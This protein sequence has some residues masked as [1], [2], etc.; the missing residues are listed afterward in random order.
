MATVKGK[1][2]GY[3]EKILAMDCETSG[4][5]FNGDDPSVGY[6]S[7]SWGLIVADAEKLKPIEELYVEIKWD[8]VSKWNRKA[9]KVH[10]LSVSYLE[11]NGV[12]EEEAVTRMGSLI[13][14]YWGPKNC[15]HTLGHNVVT[16]DL[17]FLKRLF[18]KYD[19]NLR[20]GNRHYDTNSIGWVALNSFTSQQFFESAGI[21]YGKVHNALTD[22]RNALEATRR[23]RMV[24]KSALDG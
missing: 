14:K 19:I 8:G 13:L 20:F 10:G 16:F 18:R 5:T 4:L 9:E 21:K 1:P 15:I 11:Q 3:I 2:T 17:W 12:S 7:L 24:F 22:A 6:Q 23:V